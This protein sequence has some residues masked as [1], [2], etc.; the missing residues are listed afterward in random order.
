[1]SN[2]F[3]DLLDRAE[4]ISSA[5]SGLYL[6]GVE[7]CLLALGA[8]DEGGPEPASEAARDLFSLWER[9]SARVADRVMRSPLVLRAMGDSLRVGL[10]TQRAL[11]ALAASW[12]RGVHGR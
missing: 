9:Q 7:T 11:M 10:H 6:A 5:W 2:P 4:R 8:R 3:H 12:G 1:M